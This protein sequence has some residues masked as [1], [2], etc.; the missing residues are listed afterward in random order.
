MGSSFPGLRGL[1][2]VSLY[3]HIPFCIRKCA[4]CDFFSVAGADSRTIR[5][6]IDETVRQTAYFLERLGPK[7]LTSVYLGGGTP[8]SLNAVLWRLLLKELHS[9]GAVAAPEFTVEA[10]PESLNEEFLAVCA[11]FGVT[12]LSVGIQSFRTELLKGIG[13]SVSVK[14]IRRAL[15][16]IGRNWPGDLNL[17]LLA[18]LPG[19]SARIMALDIREVVDLRPAHISCYTLTLERG[20]RLY[21]QVREGRV[22][23]PR[24]DLRDELWLASRK[25][26]TAAGYSHYEISNFALPG[27]ECIHNMG[28]WLLEPYL[29]SGPSAVSTLPTEDGSVVRIFNPR[30]LNA[31]MGGRNARWGVHWEVLTPAQLFFE[32]LMLG[33]RL[34]AGIP[35]SLF[36]GRFGR[37][38]PEIIP[39]LWRSWQARGFVQKRS[40]SYA[41]TLRARLILN[42]LLGELAQEDLSGAGIRLDWP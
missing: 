11:E 38:L 27:R 25:K 22:R 6:V 18:G 5:E 28:Y 35:A 9:L 10:N 14:N 7:T 12:R 36:S 19:Q 16:L 20:T 37:P 33:F 15:D 8:S 39:R 17:D 29:G 31:Y 26:I 24:P 1:A 41:L 21:E 42:R 4:Y 40:A 30:D 32:Q 13:R 23:L 34:K 2:R 3:I